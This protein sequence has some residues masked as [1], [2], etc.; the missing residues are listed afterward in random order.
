L[1]AKDISFYSAFLE[2]NPGPGVESES[3]MEVNCSACGRIL[4]SG[5][6]RDMCG[7]WFHKSCGNVKTQL[8]DSGKW[9]CE[10][11]KWERLFLLEEKLQ[12]AQNQIEDLKLRNK[13]LEEQLRLATTGN[14]IGRQVTEQEH[15]EGEQCLVWVIS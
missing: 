8:V 12:D 13:N 6:Q 7:R 11:C 10:R 2:Q 14:E 15:H 9:N 1:F 5:T 3:F 4:K